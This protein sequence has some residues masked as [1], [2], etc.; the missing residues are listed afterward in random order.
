MTR[1][2]TATIAMTMA[3]VVEPARTKPLFQGSYQS[4]HKICGMKGMRLAG[5]GRGRWG[6]KSGELTAPRWPSRARRPIFQTRNANGR[7]RSVVQ[8]SCSCGGGSGQGRSGGVTLRRQWCQGSDAPGWKTWIGDPWRS[9][10]WRRWSQWNRWRWRLPGAS[11]GIWTSRTTGEGSLRRGTG[12]GR[13]RREQWHGR[14]PERRRNLTALWCWCWMFRKC[15]E[16]SSVRRI[17]RPSCQRKSCLRGLFSHDRQQLSW[18]TRTSP[19]VICVLVE[20]DGL[21]S[22]HQRLSRSNCP[23]PWLRVR[24]CIYRATRRPRGAI[25]AYDI[26]CHGGVLDGRR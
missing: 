25:V 12:G 17:G 18:I 26:S 19:T 22:R 20:S 11:S 14:R 21:G 10:Q 6:A 1:I 9:R 15:W 4:D 2:A 5:W 13:S 3:P 24:G 23:Y 8:A 16:R 7:S